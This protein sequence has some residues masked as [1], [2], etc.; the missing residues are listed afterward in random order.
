MTYVQKSLEGIQQV[1]EIVIC[2]TI[3]TCVWWNKFTFQE[4]VFNVPNI[5]FIGNNICNNYGLSK[6]VKGLQQ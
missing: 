4:N 6:H 1:L 5:E 2:I 3:G